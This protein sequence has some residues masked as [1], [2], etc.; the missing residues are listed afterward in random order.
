[1]TKATSL[2]KEMAFRMPI[3]GRVLDSLLFDSCFLTSKR[4]QVIQFRTTYF[5]E[6][7]NRD[8]LDERRLDREDTLNTHVLRHLTNREALL[9]AVARDAD[10]DTAI[11]LDTLFVTLF[12][13]IRNGDRVTTLE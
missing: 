11:L 12:D 8:A 2:G 13:T 1:M 4:T 3:S 6:L 5:T 7:V 9:V 10:Y